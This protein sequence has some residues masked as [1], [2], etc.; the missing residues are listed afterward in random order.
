M[1]NLLMRAALFAEFAHRTQSREYNPEPYIVHPR[2][3]AAHAARIGLS[4]AA[5][6]AAFLHDVLEDTKTTQNELRASFPEEVVDMVV[7][8]SDLQK[9]KEGSRAVRK[10]H[11]WNRLY[12][13][14]SGE[15]NKCSMHPGTLPVITLKAIDLLDN[16]RSIAG[17]APKFWRVVQQEMA[18]FY[19]K[20]SEYMHPKVRKTFRRYV[21]EKAK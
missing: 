7:L 8:L 15:T 2:R 10:K 17:E 4:D 9:P 3:V 12:I 16:A 5:I 21:D 19:E 20:F 1:N 11:Y 18:E 13:H 6:A 14:V